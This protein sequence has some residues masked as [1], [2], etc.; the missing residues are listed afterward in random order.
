MSDDDVIES[1]EECDAS[2]HGNVPVHRLGR[3]AFGGGEE[4]EHEEAEEEA[5]GDDVDGH[6]PL[7]EREARG[8]EGLAA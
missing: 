8:R 5:D 2:E 3:R 7:A 6:A 4:A 1:C